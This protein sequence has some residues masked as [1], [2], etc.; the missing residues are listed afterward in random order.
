MSGR[1][2]RPVD[3]LICVVGDRTVREP[4]GAESRF[5]SVHVAG[6]EAALQIR[7]PGIR[8]HAG[9]G[10]RGK[11]AVMGVEQNPAAERHPIPILLQMS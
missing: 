3:S 2:E 4:D 6:N 11:D 1:V 7:F 8:V 5:D 9:G 10:V